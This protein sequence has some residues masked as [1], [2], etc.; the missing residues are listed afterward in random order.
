MGWG[1]GS[2]ALRHKKFTNEE[3]LSRKKREKRRPWR[4]KKKRKGEGSLRKVNEEE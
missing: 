4:K 2:Q 1:T 3:E